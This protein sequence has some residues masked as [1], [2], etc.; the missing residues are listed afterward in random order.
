MCNE[1]YTLHTLITLRHNVATVV[2]GA[3]CAF[4]VI[5]GLCLPSARVIWFT[6]FSIPPGDDTREIRRGR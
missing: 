2:S 6:R 3:E 1:I 5:F 4:F